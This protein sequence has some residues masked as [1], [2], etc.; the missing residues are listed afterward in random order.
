[1]L[2]PPAHGQAVTRRSGALAIVASATPAAR[3]SATIVFID[4]DPN[5]LCLG[6]SLLKGPGWSVEGFDAPTAALER[7]RKGSVDLVVVDLDL[8]EMHGRKVVAKIREHDGK[9]PVVVLTGSG[10]EE[11]AVHSF[12]AGAA[13]YVRKDQMHD[14]LLSCAKSLLNEAAGANSSGKQGGAGRLLET[15]LDNDYVV[16]RRTAPGRRPRAGAPASDDSAKP[17]GTS[18]ELTPEQVE[19]LRRQ[20]LRLKRWSELVGNSKRELRSHV[21][22]LLSDVVDVFPLDEQGRPRDREFCASFCKD[23]SRSGLSLLHPTPPESD[24]VA[25]RFPHLPGR[26]IAMICDVV[27]SRLVGPGLYEI[28]LRFV[29]RLEDDPTG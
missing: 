23:V 20:A 10:S 8:P 11:D 15:A 21:R 9:I 29:S 26:P 18:R 4:D 5:I 2:F 1:M 25:V 3:A 24:R 7:I 27:R 22:R 6:E 14:E 28:G 19:V 13:D 17:S 16:V 12:R